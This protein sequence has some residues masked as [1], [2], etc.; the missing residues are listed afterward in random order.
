MTLGSIIEADHRL[1][2]HGKLVRARK[3]VARD[4]EVWRRYEEDYGDA[5]DEREK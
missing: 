1:I 3:K 4:A 2:A 5:K